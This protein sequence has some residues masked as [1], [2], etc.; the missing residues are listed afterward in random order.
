MITEERFWELI[1]EAYI[2]GIN[3]SSERYMKETINDE[4]RRGDF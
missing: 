3:N 1:Q 4:L 2:H